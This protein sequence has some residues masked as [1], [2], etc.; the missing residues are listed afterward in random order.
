MA[1]K[2]RLE[3]SLRLAD[4]ELD[5]AQ[6]L[7]AKEMRILAKFKEDRD[8]Q[9]EV[10]VQAIEGQKQACLGQPWQ[11]SSWQLYREEQKRKLAEDEQEVLLQEEV[12][13]GFR[14]RLIKCRINLEKFK[15]LKQKKWK[16][17]NI[18]ELKKEQAVIDEIPQNQA[19]RV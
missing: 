6:S 19:G 14:E 15:R 13:T 11:L 17:Y 3:A 1:F 8:I 9:T 10:F 4:Q 16:L 5:I 2:Y 12:V 7:L 18:D